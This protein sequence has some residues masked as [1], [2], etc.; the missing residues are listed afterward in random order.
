M[1]E[2]A[3]ESTLET[4]KRY[5]KY[6][7]SDCGVVKDGSAIFSYVDGNNISITK[8]SPELCKDCYEKRYY[9]K[10]KGSGEASKIPL[11]K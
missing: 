7:C 4:T 8:N 6:K 3:L 1:L 11:P 10:F 2:N 5:E 9:N